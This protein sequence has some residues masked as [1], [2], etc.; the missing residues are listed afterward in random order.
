[1]NDGQAVMSA[2]SFF[3]M[4]NWR[5][6]GSESIGVVG[7]VRVVREVGDGEYFRPHTE[8]TEGQRFLEHRGELALAGRAQSN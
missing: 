6:E 4:R 1:M 7:V 2:H 8:G 5:A 3:S